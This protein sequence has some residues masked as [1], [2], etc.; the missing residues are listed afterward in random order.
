VTPTHVQYKLTR[1]VGEGAFGAVYEGE[2]VGEGLSR[3]VAL[4]LLHPTHTGRRVIESR[5][6]DEARMLSLIRH[7]AIVRV[8][9]LIRVDDSWCVV[10]EFV[11]GS[12]LRRLLEVGP[13]PPRAALQ[14][15]EEVASALHAAWGQ[16]GPEGKPLHLVHRDI[17]PEN[18]R[19]TPQGEVKLLDFGIARADFSAREAATQQGGMGT[20]IYMSVERFRGEDT[21]AGDVYA[22]GVTLWELLTGVPPNQS[23]ADADRRP[24]G[25]SLRPQ[26]E[27]LAGLDE[28]LFALLTR[29][30]ADEPEDRPTARECARTLAE[31]RLRVPGELL[32]DWAD[33][34]LAVTAAAPSLLPPV[35]SRPHRAASTLAP[36]RPE[37]GQ[38]VGRTLGPTGWHPLD[39]PQR[40]ARFVVAGAGAL[41]LG[42][43]FSLVVLG[44]GWWAWERFDWAGT[45]APVTTASSTPTPGSAAAGST[46]SANPAALGAGPSKA[47]NSAPEAAASPGS[48]AT[49]VPERHAVT[50]PASTDS[51][52]P[53]GTT[54]APPT[55]SDPSAESLPTEAAPPPEPSSAAPTTGRLSVTGA[56]S[57]RLDGPGGSTRA[58]DVAPGRYTATVRFDGGAEITV[59]GV[60]VEAGRT[61]RL[62]CDEAFA[63]CAV[64][65]P[66]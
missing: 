64:D 52:Q 56:A 22:L 16:A 42:G 7:R 57:V 23:A 37:S 4:K 45:T 24:P 55:P 19:L 48:R 47:P 6:R 38:Y 36:Q 35:A 13:I 29:M 15:A 62:R 53:S 10:M 60:R 49:A 17:K 26:W 43:L 1:L 28:G 46:P 8:D 30:M 44:A 61:T 33:A 65:G 50:E 11:E 40:R 66:D 14:I 59:A 41:L 32:E 39:L 21:H 5:L 63:N 3:R 2:R 51:P 20:V 12:D 9:D 27:W 54:P 31:L 18:I 58:G 25:R 34:A